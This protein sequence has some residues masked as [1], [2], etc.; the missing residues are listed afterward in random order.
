MMVISSNQICASHS[1][2][3]KKMIFDALVAETETEVYCLCL[4][5]GIC[6][7]HDGFL[8]NSSGQMYVPNTKGLHM[9]II[10]SYHDMP[11]TG[12]PGYQKTHELIKRQYYWPRLPSNVH[13]YVSHCD[14]CARF[15]GSNMKPAST[16]IPLQPSMMPWVDVTMDFITNL[17]LS[18][19][20][21]SILTV[22]DCFSKEMEFIPCNKTTMALDT[23][24][25]YLFHVWKDHGLQ[26]ALQVINNLCK[27]L[28]ITPKLST[29]HHP[30]M[31]GQMEVMNQE[32]HQ[33]L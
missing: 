19:G 14:Q 13:S 3:I 28:G 7:E 1:T 4:E 12:H 29:V 18:N 25:L 26:F 33:Y 6:K 21:N 11:I 16:A 30:Q 8:Y 2:D 20:Y 17:P 15:K 10:T 5:K 32:V 9:H 23:T 24:K 31:D 22:V 27:R